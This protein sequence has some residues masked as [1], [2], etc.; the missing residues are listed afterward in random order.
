MKSALTLHDQR[1]FIKI[2]Y[3]R[4]GKNKITFTVSVSTRQTSSMLRRG[5]GSNSNAQRKRT[6]ENSTMARLAWVAVLLTACASAHGEGGERKESPRRRYPNEIVRMEGHVFTEKVQSQHVPKSVLFYGRHGGARREGHR[7]AFTCFRPSSGLLS[8]AA[9]CTRWV[10]P[11]SLAMLIF[12][13]HV[14]QGL[15]N[16]ESLHAVI[17][18]TVLYGTLLYPATGENV[19]SERCDLRRNPIVISS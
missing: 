14:R 6:K 8:I 11:W 9:S 16:S 19:V 1:D 10:M 13:R 12:P 7:N 17:H 5:E 18:T 4:A 3:N 2:R 15:R